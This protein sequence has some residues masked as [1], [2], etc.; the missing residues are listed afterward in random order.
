MPAP[1]IAARSSLLEA[2]SREL[3]RPLQ[4][5]GQDNEGQFIHLPPPVK[6][7][8]EAARLAALFVEG[9]PAAPPLQQ[10]IDALARLRRNEN[11][12]S[13]RDWQLISW[14][15]C[16]DCGDFGK[17]IEEAPLFNAVMAHAHSWIAVRDVPRKSWFGLLNGYFSY[18]QRVKGQGNWLRLRQALVDTLPI[19][20]AGL[21][22]PKLWSRVLSQHPDILT[23]DAGRSLHHTIFF[24]KSNELQEVVAGLAIPDAS[25][26][27][28]K[29]ISRQ[30]DHLNAL[31]DAEFIQIIP[32]MLAFLETKHLYA[33][34]ILATLLTRYC[35]S[36]RRTETHEL[37]KNTSFARWGNPQLIGSMRWSK[38]EDPVR[39]MVLRWFAKDDLEHFFNLLQGKGQVDQA[40]LEYWL[41]F[42]DQISYT[43][44]LLGGDAWV[45]TDPE[46]RNFRKLNASRCGQLV[47]G[48]KHNN[49]FIMQINDQYIVEFS[50]TGNACYVYP[51][52]Q[53]PFSP[54]AKSLHTDLNLKQKILDAR[55]DVVNKL[56]HYSGWQKNIDSF[57]AQR[58]IRPGARS[59]AAV[60]VN[61][62][63]IRLDMSSETAVPQISVRPAVEANANTLKPQPQPQVRGAEP[64]APA[65][66]FR[67]LAPS[68][69]TSP[70]LQ[71]KV[72]SA[73]EL[74]EK[75]KLKCIDNLSKGGA[76]WIVT[77]EKYSPIGIELIRLGMHFS[78]GK[79]FWIK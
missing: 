15:L 56:S 25:W 75:N 9:A 30:I 22:R 2:M 23:D 57:L 72:Q 52:N 36:A 53:L 44:I 10:R 43:R 33:D 27:W 24:G 54:E 21:K 73:I 45:N 7:P 13:R 63:R 35:Q 48:P 40:R 61:S 68:V 26:L 20:V 46:F 4:R 34:D 37:L 79:G 32:A 59:G 5:L 74:A 6:L 66:E 69:T 31:G 71:T 12:L 76:F 3:S 50:G 19:L 41:R 77:N 42:V 65:P 29:I 47:G 55:G 58:G 62:Y 78:P 70:S 16:D 51:E 14:G 60:K 18:P 8:A 49:A 17:P 38:V 67:E 11:D 64:S 28:R 39:K 1:M